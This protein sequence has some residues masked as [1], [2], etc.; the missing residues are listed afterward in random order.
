MVNQVRR[1]ALLALLAAGALS[2]CLF[3]PEKKAPRTTR[4]PIYLDPTNINQALLNMIA[5]YE[6]RDSVGT[7]AVYDGSYQGSSVDLKDPRPVI[8]LNRDDEKHH[9]NALKQNPN[10]ASIHIDFGP[11]STWNRLPPESGDDPDWAILQINNPK[12]EVQDVQS[13]T[14]F[15]T[16]NVNM[17]YTFKP[18]VSAPG[19]T[20]WAIIRW[21]E[22]RSP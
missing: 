7:E 8:T 10:I 22:V 18:T 19:D 4:P 3:S 20:L 16:P 15:Q 13:G 1:A 12:I 17:L 11:Q 9:V 14:L 21:A 6:A 2:G 5:A